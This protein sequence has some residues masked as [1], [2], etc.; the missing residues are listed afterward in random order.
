MYICFQLQDLAVSPGL[1]DPQL[2]TAECVFES[3]EPKLA[4]NTVH[5]AYIK[6]TM[7][8]SFIFSFFCGPWLAIITLIFFDKCKSNSVEDRKNILPMVKAVKWVLFL[9][10]L[11]ECGLL[12]T[13]FVFLACHSGNARCHIYPILIILLLEGLLM[14]V[15]LRD[16]CF[17]KQFLPKRSCCKLSYWLQIITGIFIWANLTAYHFCWLVIGIMLNTLWGV[18]VLLFV[19]VI[20]AAFIFTFYNYYYMTS[21]NDFSCH[22]F[23]IC[24]TFCLPIGSLVAVVVLAGQSGFGKNTTDDVVKTVTLSITTAFISWVLSTMKKSDKTKVSKKKQKKKGSEEL[25]LSTTASE[26]RPSA[27]NA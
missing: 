8:F 14:G 2:N 20:I 1:Q 9:M 4:K 7:W 23:F 3:H 24:A 16:E 21:E 22:N 19:C 11:V 5:S 10:F 13:V 25:P 26:E 27:P 18:T 6:G 12:I 17:S 15:F